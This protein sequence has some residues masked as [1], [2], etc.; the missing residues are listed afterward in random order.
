MDLLVSRGL[1]LRHQGE[2]DVRT[3][4]RVAL[5]LPG[6]GETF[7]IS[8]TI[9]VAFDLRLVSIDGKPVEVG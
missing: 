3:N 9:R 7:A 2:M 4:S 1:P 6:G 8:S 5:A